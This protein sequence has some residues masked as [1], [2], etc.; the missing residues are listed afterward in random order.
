[1]AFLEAR[2]TGLYIP[3]L[4][5]LLCSAPIVSL[6][7]NP[8]NAHQMPLVPE[9]IA[10]R[11]YRKI[12]ERSPSVMIG[13]YVLARDNSSRGTKAKAV[14]ADLDLSCSLPRGL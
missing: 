8:L 2:N 14:G 1:M 5:S 13:T 10:G 7:L 11:D 12:A 6:T 3:D 4:K 9:G